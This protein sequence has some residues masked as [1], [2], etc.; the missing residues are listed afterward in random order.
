MARP[1]GVDI[2]HIQRPRTAPTTLS[3]NGP[4]FFWRIA[5]SSS[6][7]ITNS[8]SS[9]RTIVLQ[10]SASLSRTLSVALITKL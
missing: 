3:L 9:G 5:N 6:L 1:F 7:R 2:Q 8:I 4:R 10:I